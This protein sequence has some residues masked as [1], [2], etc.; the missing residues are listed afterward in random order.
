MPRSSTAAKKAEKPK[1]LVPQP[2]GGALLRGGSPGNRG[3]FSLP[4]VVRST[5]RERWADRIPML[6]A[7][8]DGEPIN[9]VSVPLSAVLE[10]AKCPSCKGPLKPADARATV[11]IEGQASASAG[12]RVRAMSEMS[13]VGFG[14]TLTHDDVRERVRAM[15][16]I[17]SERDIWSSKDAIDAIETVWK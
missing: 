7:I 15:L 11:M 1:D 3:G 13:R 14:P 6:T 12:E 17:L 10:H 9:K 5:A 8:A 2:H 4:S 16:Q